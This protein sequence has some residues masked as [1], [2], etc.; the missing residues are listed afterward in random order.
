MYFIQHKFSCLCSNSSSYR[1]FPPFSSHGVLHWNMLAIEVYVKRD[2]WWRMQFIYIPTMATY[3]LGL[4]FRVH[5]PV[6]NNL[7]IHRS[8]MIIIPYFFTWLPLGD[9]TI[10]CYIICIIISFYVCL[11]SK[12]SSPSE[13]KLWNSFWYVFYYCAFIVLVPFILYT[14]WQLLT[15]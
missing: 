5:L 10:F 1:T 2:Y 8:K 15:L 14:L 4:Y 7:I 13:P 11:N 12:I 3:S 9:F 6:L